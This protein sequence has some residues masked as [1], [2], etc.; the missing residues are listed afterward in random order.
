MTKINMN[1]EDNSYKELLNDV[2]S[3]YPNDSK[4]QIQALKRQHNSL[5]EL[6]GSLDV[7]VTEIRKR[8]LGNSINL[9]NLN[10]EMLYQALFTLSYLLPNDLPDHKYK[11]ALNKINPVTEE[12]IKNRQI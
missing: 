5:Y 7:A 11:E 10:V 12:I 4:E 2:K 9:G 3:E 6:M 8:D 1:H